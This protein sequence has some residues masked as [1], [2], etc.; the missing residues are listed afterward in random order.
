MLVSGGLTD[1]EKIV[2]GPPTPRQVIPLT[3]AHQGYM[4][5]HRERFAA[6]A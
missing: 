6:S 1:P 4:R 2:F 5:H 3:P